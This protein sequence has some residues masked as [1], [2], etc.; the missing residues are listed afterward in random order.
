MEEF[1]QVALS[2]CYESP[3]NTRRHFNEAALKDLTA[4]VTSTGVLTPILVRE[5]PSKNGRYEILAGTRRCRAAR[6]AQIEHVPARVCEFTDDEALEV[7]VIENLQRED[8]GPLEEADGYK[9]LL[10]RPGYDVAGIAAKVGKSEAYVYGRL[11]LCDLIKPAKKALAAEE[12]TAGH[13]L[14]LA[15]LQPTDQTEAFDECFRRQWDGRKD[16]KVAASV[17]ELAAWIHS[18]LQLDL[19]HVPFLTGDA[20]LVPAA[21]S[22]T[23]CPKR[24][25]FAPALFPDIGKK[26]VC[27]DRACYQDKIAAHIARTKAQLEAEAD[28]GAVLEISTRWG[29]T[30]KG[31]PLSASQWTEIKRG[32]KKC[33]HEQQ[34][35][36][37][38]G[39]RE[40]GKVLTICAA[41]ECKVHH[42]S[43]SSSFSSP[44]AKAQRAKEA[45]KQRQAAELRRRIFCA[46]HE[47]APT[48]LGRAELNQLIAGYLEEMQQDSLRAL[49]QALGLETTKKTRGYAGG[50]TYTDWRAT[51]GKWAEDLD[52]A[53][54]AR[55]LVI[56][57]LVPALEGRDWT[58]DRRKGLLR[59]AAAL[60]G[61]DVTTIKKALAGEASQ[62]KPATAGVPKKAAAK[63][64][65]KTVP[66][67]RARKAKKAKKATAA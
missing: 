4:S 28:G 51:L 57:P 18:N 9:A 11:K 62:A 2:D 29:E 31:G 48:K 3:L 60:Y 54:L 50:A 56:L 24:S 44:A 55:A 23:L 26:D 8:L 37:V 49:V 58:S 67:A 21:G 5:R 22:C 35:L 20:D 46:I 63:P 43:H 40:L 10:A 30:K 59:K 64:K 65:K 34:G 17:R 61:V 25:G 19:A 53:G 15:R 66:A 13:A 52:D 32:Q 7:V 16:V 47:A 33:G 12:I 38:A 14:L 27:T 45:L 42:G 39:D 1:R 36:V 6:A 41:A